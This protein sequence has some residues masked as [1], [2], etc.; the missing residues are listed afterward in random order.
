M[1]VVAP[2]H[3]PLVNL[4]PEERPTLSIDET[5][6]VL[7]ISRGSVYEA[8]HAG[9]VPVLRFGRRLRVPTAALRAMLALSEMPVG[10]AA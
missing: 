7:G 4:N 9:E 10:D 3:R 2:Q 6:V 1:S 8:V 5:A